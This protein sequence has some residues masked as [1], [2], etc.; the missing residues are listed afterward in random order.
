[1]D[2]LVNN[3]FYSKEELIYEYNFLEYAISCTDISMRSKSSYEY[4]S[5]NFR[6]FNE[7]FKRLISNNYDRGFTSKNGVRVAIREFDNKEIFAAMLVGLVNFS[8]NLNSN[9]SVDMMDKYN[10]NRC[11]KMF[12]EVNNKNIDNLLSSEAFSDPN[13]L[14]SN[15]S[16]TFIGVS[17]NCKN[18]VNL[19]KNNINEENII[20]NQ[21]KNKLSNNEVFYEEVRR[22]K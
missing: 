15:I 20:I 9:T 3:N 10:C 4:I 16:R 18:K 6:Y 12:F 13:S 2:L 7:A 19:R 22:G 14:I 17:L 1:M 5:D 8:N 21:I 11:L